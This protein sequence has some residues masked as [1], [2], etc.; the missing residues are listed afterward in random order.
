MIAVIDYG[1]GNLHSVQKALE[2]VGAKVFVTQNADEIKQAQKLVLPGVGAMQQA[3]ERLNYLGLVDV[4]KEAVNQNK[5]FLGICL[6][7]QLLFQESQE[8]G[9]VKGLGIIPG[10][11]KK[12]SNLKVPHIGWNQIKKIN[13]E[14]PLFKD[15]PEGAFFY[16]CHSYYVEPKDLIW[17][18]TQTE[19][20]TN[21]A[22]S[23]CGNNIFGVQFHPEKSHILGL[24]VLENFVRL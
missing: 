14:C 1:M 2:F 15:I 6:G 18:A 24:K 10:S 9:Q 19:Y 16:F 11:V 4:I 3:M 17:I 8:G 7:L 22:S 23:I 5:P 21:F 20:A 12:L 13:P